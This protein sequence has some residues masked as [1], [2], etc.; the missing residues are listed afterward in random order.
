MLLTI[1]IVLVVACASIFAG[2]VFRKHV[3]EKKFRMPSLR[4]SISWSR[5]EKKLRISAGK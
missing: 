2:Y 5:L 1:L 4:P 3:A